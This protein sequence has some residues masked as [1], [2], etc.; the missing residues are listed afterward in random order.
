MRHEHL[1][2][3]FRGNEPVARQ[4]E[5]R[6]LAYAFTLRFLPALEICASGKWRKHH[7]LSERQTRSLREPERGIEGVFP[8][9]RQPENERAHDVHSVLAKL[10]QLL[11]KISACSV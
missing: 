11:D 1:R 2:P 6:N 9:R 5:S 7:E 3:D 10:L 4:R 8:V